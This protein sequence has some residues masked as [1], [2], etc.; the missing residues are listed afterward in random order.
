MAD[1]TLL[2]D[3]EQIDPFEVFGPQ[4]QLAVE[5]LAFVGHL[6]KEIHF[7]GHT[8]T[9]KT[10]RPGEKAAAAVAHKP[11]RGSIAEAEVW[12]N[13]QVG[14]ALTS[15]DGDT[16]FCP[17]VGP[18]IN[19]FARARLRRITDTQRGFHQ[20]T[21]DYIYGHYIAL[22]QEAFAAVEALQNLSERNREQ[23]PPSPDS[24]TEQ[25]I[26]LDEIS[27]DSLP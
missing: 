16:D 3:D 4:I 12:A 9:I 15:I 17:P 10:L 22:E 24:S 26:S 19:E 1:E 5:G 27:L 23:S 20:P 18:D 25:G 11:W 7:C 21:L 2:I 13:V 14:L 8:F 6:D